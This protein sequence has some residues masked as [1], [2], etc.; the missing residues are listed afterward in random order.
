MATAM[1]VAHEYPEANHAMAVPDDASATAGSANGRTQHT[2]QSTAPAAVAI[3]TP[4][5]VFSGP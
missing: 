2:P 1:V 5:A 4:Q 3:A